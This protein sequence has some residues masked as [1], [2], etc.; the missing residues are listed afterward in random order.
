MNEIC[1]VYKGMLKPII[2]SYK[3]TTCQLLYLKQIPINLENTTYNTWSRT[4]NGRKKESLL[5]HVY[6]NNVANVKNLNYKVPTFGDHFLIL[7]EFNFKMDKDDINK[8]MRNWKNYS[9]TS[10]TNEISSSIRLTNYDTHDLTVQDLWNVLEG[11]I[12]T[13]IDKLAP[14]CKIVQKVKNVVVPPSIKNKI[15]KRKRLLT[16]DKNLGVGNH[17]PDIK[18]LNGEINLYFTSLKTDRV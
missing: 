6:V 16:L 7:T 5:D 4:I 15:N 13:A 11:V 1:P 14:L 18:L 17:A 12:I 8:V 2:T 10:L 9:A 3:L